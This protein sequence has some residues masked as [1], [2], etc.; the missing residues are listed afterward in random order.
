MNKNNVKLTPKTILFSCLGAIVVFIVIIGICVYA[1]GS[2]VSKNK[3]SQKSTILQKEVDTQTDIPN[4]NDI[5]ADSNQDVGN[6][7]ILEL[8]ENT[9]TKE[10]TSFDTVKIKYNND[11]DIGTYVIYATK[12]GTLETLQE[13]KEGYQDVSIWSDVVDSLTTQ[14]SL[15]YFQANEIEED[16]KNDVNIIFHLMN[17]LNDNEDLALLTIINGVVFYNALEE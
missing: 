16:S 10:I 7:Q 1:A 13:I 14:I 8:L 12:E 11:N 5:N 15:S 2:S 3:D 6:T 4:Y 9:Y 17:D